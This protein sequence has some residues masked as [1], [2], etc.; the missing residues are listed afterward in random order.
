MARM[1]KMCAMHYLKRRIFVYSWKR[2]ASICDIIF[3]RNFWCWKYWQWTVSTR[4]RGYWSLWKTRTMMVTRFIW[5]CLWTIHQRIPLQVREYTF[6]IVHI[7]IS[8]ELHT[9]HRGKTGSQNT[10]LSGSSVSASGSSVSACVCAGARACVYVRSKKE[11]FKEV[12]RP[13]PGASFSACDSTSEHLRFP[14]MYDTKV[15]R[16]YWTAS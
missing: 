2:N 5:M 3:C 8:I 14:T 4:C 12:D 11:T 10:C 13:G 7:Q 9:T 16:F 1:L 6:Q 15:I